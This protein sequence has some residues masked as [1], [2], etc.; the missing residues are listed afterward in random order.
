[1]RRK[2]RYDEFIVTYLRMLAENDKLTKLIQTQIDTI[3]KRKKTNH[4]TRITSNKIR[5]NK[6]KKK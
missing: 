3:K 1:M 6:L 4:L 5:K 2:H